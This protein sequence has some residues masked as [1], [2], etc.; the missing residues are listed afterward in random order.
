MVLWVG[1]TGCRA[2]R[3]AFDA[4]PLLYQILVSMLWLVKCLNVERF[5][6]FQNHA[7]SIIGKR[8]F[9][10]QLRFWARN[11]NFFARFF[12]Y[13]STKRRAKNMCVVYCKNKNKLPNI[14]L[15]VY[16]P[17]CDKLWSHLQTEATEFNTHC[18]NRHSKGTPPVL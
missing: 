4:A 13:P 6:L 14:E 8:V 2:G 17:K 18:I 7:P 3:H 9:L 11:S 12:A 16:S 15:F 1:E 10:K 5:V